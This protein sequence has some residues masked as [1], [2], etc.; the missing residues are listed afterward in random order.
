MILETLPAVM[1]LNSQQ[2]SQLVEELWEEWLP[3]DDDDTRAAIVGLLDAR[4]SHYREHP[5]TASSWD[6]VKQRIERL[7][8]CRL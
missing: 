5:E 2:R 1:Q 8:Q 7:R 3:R 4:M 6:E